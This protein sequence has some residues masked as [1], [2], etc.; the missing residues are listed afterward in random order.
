VH[1]TAVTASRKCPLPLVSSAG[2]QWPAVTTVACTAYSTFRT[3]FCY[4]YSIVCELMQSDVSQLERVNKKELTDQSHKLSTDNIHHWCSPEER[5]CDLSEQHPRHKHTVASM[6][7]T[8]LLQI[9]ECKIRS[10]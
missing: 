2:V 6:T 4:H 10:D 5:P 3:C 9:Y 1:A 8:K 7:T